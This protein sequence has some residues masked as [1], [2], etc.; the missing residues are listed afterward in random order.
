LPYVTVKHGGAPWSAPA[1]VAATWNTMSVYITVVLAV[2]NQIGLKGSKMLVAL[3]AIKLHA[4]PFTIGVLISMYALFPL[5]LAVYAGRYSD[6]VGVRRPLVLGS[7]GMC[8]S[9]L[10]PALAPSLAV[11]FVSAALVG[12]A[13][14]FFHVA[15]HNL[16]GALGDTHERTRNFGTFSLGAAVSSM[17]GPMLV[18]F[19]IDRAGYSLT[20]YVLTVIT[21]L[22]ALFL[23]C[24]AKFIPALVV[25][26]QAAADGGVRDLLKLPKLRNTLLTSGVILTAIDLFNFYMPIHGTAIGLSASVIGIILGMQAA[27]AFVV[28]LWMPWMSKRFGEMQ[29]LNWSLAISGLTFFLFPV[30][31]NPVVLA[32]I[33]FLLG[34]GLGCGQPLSIILTY[35]HSPPGRSGEAL[36][37]RLFVNKLTQIMVPVIFGSLG[38]AFGIVPIFWTNGLLLMWG[39]YNNS[40]HERTPD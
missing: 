4:S 24:Y 7:L 33:S 13:N 38:S 18:G 39:G 11:L 34:L 16:I 5:G 8:A 36:G 32:S 37:L 30:F 2:L 12:V 14:I 17:I 20:Y 19:M 31:E 6:R 27:A 26:K 28:R 35:N 29:V 25:G 10:L 1:A 15:S 9:L 22:P 23:M 21:L 3:Y 40:R